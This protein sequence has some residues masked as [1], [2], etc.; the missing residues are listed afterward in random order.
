MVMAISKAMVVLTIVANLKGN[1]TLA[2]IRQSIVASVISYNYFF[3]LKK[4][5]AKPSNRSRGR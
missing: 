1:N 3:P 5:V 2:H 4:N